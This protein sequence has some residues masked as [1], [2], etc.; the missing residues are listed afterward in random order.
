VKLVR[1]IV[2]VAAVIGTAGAKV[3]P[4]VANTGGTPPLCPP[5]RICR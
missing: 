1:L 3:E 2:L 4:P 5:D